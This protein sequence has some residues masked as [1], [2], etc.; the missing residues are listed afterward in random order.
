[1]RCPAADAGVAIG[2]GQY[3]HDVFQPLLGKKLDESKLTGQY[4]H[5]FTI[6]VPVTVTKDNFQQV[7][8]TTCKDKPAIR[9]F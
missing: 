9:P 6:P 4:G 3:Q 7:F 8:T 1:M 5:M 2:V